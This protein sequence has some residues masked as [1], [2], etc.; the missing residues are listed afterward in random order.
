[1]QPNSENKSVEKQLKYF[2]V[3]GSLSLITMVGI[4]EIQ[5][6]YI[7]RLEETDRINIESATRSIQG[8]PSASVINLET[9]LENI[10]T[11]AARSSSQVNYVDKTQAKVEPY[12]N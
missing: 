2:C 5:G 6:I 7:D 4:T 1:M 3:V 11:D 8:N 10:G 12:S 9:T